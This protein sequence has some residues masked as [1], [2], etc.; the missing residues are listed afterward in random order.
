MK[1]KLLLGCVLVAG[2]AAACGEDDGDDGATDAGGG[3]D[4]TDTYANYAQAFF[5]DKCN[6]CHDAAGFK[7][8]G[9]GEVQLDTQAL[10]VQHKTHVIEHAVE[11]KPA[12][13]PFGTQGLPE[14]ERMRLKKWYDCGAK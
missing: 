1:S 7:T 9:G 13:M 5:K 11:L 8:L 10:V 3:G 14:P 2:L 4:C 6:T 12:I